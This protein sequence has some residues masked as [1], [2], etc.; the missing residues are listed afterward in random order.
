MR[1]NICKTSLQ[2]A[3]IQEMERTSIKKEKR[4]NPTE[5]CAKDLN[6]Q[7]TKEDVQMANTLLKRCSTSLVIRETQ[8]KTIMRHHCTHIRMAKIKMT[9]NI[10]G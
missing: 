5:K 7:S 8:T 4:K 2:R 3:H 10:M 6:R 9:N 1:E